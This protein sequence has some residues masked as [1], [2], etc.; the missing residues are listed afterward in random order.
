MKVDLVMWTKNGEKTLLAVLNRISLVIPSEN[1]GNRIIVDD[2]SVDRTRRIARLFGWKVVDNEG[3]G[4][5][6][7]ANTALKHVETEYFASFEQDVLLNWGWWDSIPPF[8]KDSDVAVASGVRL[9]VFSK[10]L[11]KISEYSLEKAR[12]LG[13][14]YF[15][16]LDNTIYKTSVIRGLGGF[17][18]TRMNVD[19]VLAK[20]IKGT[21]FKWV[22]D[23]DT[24]SI[25]LK[26][27]LDEVKSQYFYGKFGERCN[28]KT[29][30]RTAFS[31]IR[32][33]QVA[34]K[35]KHCQIMFIYPLLRLSHFLGVLRR[36]LT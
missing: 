18:K 17:P 12:R 19:T 14:P 2:D 33:L 26:S 29:V 34:W 30:M 22:V 32:G 21:G 11:F 10:S 36:Y 4:I 3:S 15:K 27:V 20:Q 13:F 25:H 28:A 7:G 8:L 9:P 6:D 16:T 24:V 23:A 5:S 35:K 1:V 31:P